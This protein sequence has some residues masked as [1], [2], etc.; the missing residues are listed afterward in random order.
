MK[1]SIDMLKVDTISAKF[2]TTLNS[3]M[4]ISGSYKLT[5]DGYAQA[6]ISNYFTQGRMKSAFGIGYLQ[7][8]GRWFAVNVSGSVAPQRRVDMGMGLMLRGFFFQTYVSVDN[9]W[10]TINLP[11]ASGLNVKL[12]M[13]FLFGKPAASKKRERKNKVKVDQHDSFDD[14]PE[15]GADENLDD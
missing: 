10:N 2:T 11:Q 15:K 3:R 14:L 7:N 13:N 4:F 5:K 1:D 12:G 9:V 8:V 6:T